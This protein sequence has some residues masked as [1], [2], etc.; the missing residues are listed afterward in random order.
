MRILIVIFA[1]LCFTAATFASPAGKKQAPACA[2][3]C[4]DKY[5]PICAKEKSG[6]KLITFGNECVMG[7]FNCEHPDGQYD[8]KTKGE[9]GG[10][11][12]VRLS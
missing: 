3:D 6:S 4:G 12:S 10:N 1:V 9:C 11:V 5:E 7:R 8:I 2:R